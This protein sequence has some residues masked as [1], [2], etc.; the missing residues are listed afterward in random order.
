MIQWLAK[1]L[2]IVSLHNMKAFTSL[3]LKLDT[4][5]QAHPESIPDFLLIH[6]VRTH[7]IKFT[8]LSNMI[9]YRNSACRT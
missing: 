6:L 7:C 8:D 3:H 4:T 5:H 1:L 2:G 9:G